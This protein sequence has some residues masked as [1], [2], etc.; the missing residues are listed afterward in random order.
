MFDLTMEQIYWAA[1]FIGLMFGGG[2]TTAIMLQNRP[3]CVRCTQHK[4][5]A[6]LVD[7]L[8]VKMCEPCENI[9]S[10]YNQ[11]M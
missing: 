4:P 1:L 2:V 6:E 8:G 7:F 10:Y 9:A 3:R 11:V 5:A